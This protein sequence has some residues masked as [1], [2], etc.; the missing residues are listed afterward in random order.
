[1]AAREDSPA[2][3]ARRLLRAA[4]S[5]AFGTVVG[6]QPFVSL[7]TPATAPDLSVLLLL[8]SLS[9]HSR[10]LNADARCSLLVTGAPEGAN[11]QTAP[12]VTVTGLAEAEPDPGAK[13]R[14][15]AVHPYAAGYADFA[16]FAIW[17]IRPAQALLVGGFARAARLRHRELAPDPAA[18]AAIAAA[19]EG[20]MAHCNTDHPD[21]LA[22]IAGA[23][24]RAWRMAGVDVDG[25]DLASGEEVKRIAWSAPA[26][27]SFS[28]PATISSPTR[29]WKTC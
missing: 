22:V 24:G 18:V 26:A 1:M 10:H 4:R 2:W 13:A 6:G 12:R 5:G 3:E 16:D 25:C 11:P 21:A 17:R 23:N 29:R 15:L 14:W 20:I 7:V 27:G 19:A 8:S 9:E 28:R